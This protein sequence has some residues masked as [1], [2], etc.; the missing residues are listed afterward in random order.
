MYL[1]LALAWLVLAV[2]VLVWQ[3]ITG[4][5]HWSIPVGGYQV[6]YGW[7]LFLFV[8]YN[9]KRWRD[10]RR[11][12]LRYRQWQA[13]QAHQLADARRHAGRAQPEAPSPELNFTDGR[14]P[15]GG[16]VPDRPAASE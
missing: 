16:P 1:Y 11:A 9:L 15:A 12:R 8:L 4:D 6:S 3:A 2:A 10:V 5:R 14:T 13:E 7:F